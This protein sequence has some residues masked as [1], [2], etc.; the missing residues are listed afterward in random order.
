MLIETF[1]TCKLSNFSM[2][3]IHMMIF[4]EKIGRSEVIGQVVMSFEN[5]YFTLN[6]VV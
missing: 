5:I 3:S 1:L 2:G 6:L 4:Y